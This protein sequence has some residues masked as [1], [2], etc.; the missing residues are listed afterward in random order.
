[1][2]PTT[3]DGL[4][5]RVRAAALL[6][7]AGM[8][9]ELGSGCSGGSGSPTT[10][11]AVLCSPDAGQCGGTPVEA[12]GCAT[13]K[14]GQTYCG[15]CA[16]SSASPCSYCP[17]NDACPSNPCGTECPASLSSTTGGSTTGGSGG[18][19]TGITCSSSAV[20]SKS[21]ACPYNAGSCSYAACAC[22]TSCGT[23]GWYSTTDGQTFVYGTCGKSDQ[24]NSAAMAVLHH[25]G[26]I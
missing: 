21:S 24:V 19:P 1:M 26:C 16:P 13:S 20:C 12:N 2:S 15:F 11:A 25:C 22:E 5:L 8:A 3:R 14:N 17:T 7:C 10:F 23:A 4:P 6:L 9:T 18:V